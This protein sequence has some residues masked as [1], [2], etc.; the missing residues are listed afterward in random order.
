M[1]K[2]FM[3]IALL[4]IV[5]SLSVFADD[6]EHDEYYDDDNNHYYEKR[7]KKRKHKYNSY[8]SDKIVNSKDKS[9]YQKECSACHF[10][11]QPELL[12]KRSWEAIMNK[13]ENHF[14]TDA[15]LEKN[16]KNEILKYL[17]NNAGDAKYVSYKYFR[18]INR[19]ISSDQTPI[20]ITKVRYF[21]KE[22]RKIPKKFITQDEVKSLSHCQKCHITAEKGNYSEHNI[23]IPNYGKWDD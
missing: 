8:Q 22:H 2:Y 21:I 7:Y 17:V 20:R 5:F 1:K 4:L 13:L 16:D 18:K 3:L 12:P 23:K 15:F 9:L 6:D 11:Y 14:D 10:A 19:S